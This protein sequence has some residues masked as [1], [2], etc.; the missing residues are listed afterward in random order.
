M[1]KNIHKVMT[2][3]HETK[4]GECLAQSQAWRKGADIPHVAKEVEEGVCA[5]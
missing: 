2:W 1:D 5:R 3:I 4:H